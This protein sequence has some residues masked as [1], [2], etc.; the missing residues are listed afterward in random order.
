MI[1]QNEILHL[2]LGKPEAEAIVT[3]FSHHLYKCRVIKRGSEAL[4]CTMDYFPD[5]V[6]LMLDENGLVEDIKMG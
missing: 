3:A 6:N 1:D 4:M 2:I 5:R